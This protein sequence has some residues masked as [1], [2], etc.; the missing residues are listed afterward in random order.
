MCGIAGVVDARGSDAAGLR[1]AVGRMTASLAHRGP[2]GEDLW[3]DADG[4]VALGH[5]RLSIVDLTDAGRQPMVSACG[6]YVLTYNGEIYNAPELM[7]ELTRLGVTFRGHSDTE[8]LLEACA[9]WGVRAA[10]ERCIGMFA[11]A[12][13]DRDRCCLTLARDRLGI[14]PLYWGRFGGLF[15][16]GSELKALRAHPGWSP[17][18]D[19]EALAAYLR[20]TYVPTPLSIYQGVRK[21]PPGHLLTLPHNGEPEESCFWDLRAIAMAGQRSRDDRPEAALVDDLQDRLRDAV[22]RRMIADVPLGAFLSGGI[23]SSL[24]VS[25][26]QEVSDRPVQTFTIGF[27]EPGFDEAPHARAVARHLGTDHHE[28]TVSPAEAR[29]VIPDLATWYDEP[30]SDSSQIPTHLVSRLARTG[31]TVALSGD[32]GDEGFAGYNRYTWVDRLWTAGRALPWRLRRGVA[33]ALW[34]VPPA[35][36]DCAAWAVPGR[37]RPPQAGDKVHKLAALASRRS[38]EAMYRQLVSHWPEPSALLPGV[39]EPAGVLDDPGLTADLPRLVPRLQYLDM[40][41]YLHDDILT[42]VDRASMAVALEVRVPL[43]DHRV[44]EFAWRLPEAA[45]IH[46]GARKWLLRRTLDRYV[47]RH[48]LD[49]PKMGFGVPIGDWLRGPLRD[50]AE[51]LIGEHRL[52]AEGLFDPK[53]IRRHWEEHLS[54]RRNHQHMLWNILM[55]QAWR[56][57]WSM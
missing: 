17:S 48:L 11:F 1:Q 28:L 20:F 56:E 15:L 50:W 10:V 46:G 41:T 54:G 47:P 32:G 38:P 19:R 27:P 5:R 13:W 39:R 24:V 8:V 22:G 33:A 36:W 42:K 16:F 37:Y 26:M 40:A 12:L 34:A 44:I 55:A 21:L 51:G 35:A 49:R 7:P 9:A 25:V 53:P 2:D 4:G 18:L 31:V 29:A 14:K 6:R 52:A 43:L 23:D 57:R 45:K 3:A 30:F